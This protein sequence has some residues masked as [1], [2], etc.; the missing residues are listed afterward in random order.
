MSV[1]S[2]ARERFT[3]LIGRPETA[4]ELLE[5]ALWIAA[6]E[7]NDVDPEAVLAE[8]GTLADRARELCGAS[9]SRADR[10]AGLERIF[11]GELG[12]RGNA[13]DYYDPCNSDVAWV[14]RHRR[15]IPITLSVIFMEI[16]RRLGLEVEGV[17]FPG[18]FLVRVR[19]DRDALI[20]VFEARTLSEAD[21][22]A[23][24][25]SMYG[26]EA[27]LETAMLRACTPHEIL[28]RMLRNLKH[29]HLRRADYARALAC[30]DRLLLL[31][32]DAT[33]ELH[34]RGALYL[35]LECP[36]AAL[37]DLE[38]YLTLAPDGEAAD[39]VRRALEPL[40]EQAARLH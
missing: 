37:A 35:R 6:E 33:A 15:G 32:P 28:A 34:D 3:E 4:A 1:E 25:R 8:L 36:Q 9:A 23:K 5:A 10:L 17:G 13:E 2:S 18:H 22:A 40:R 26:D 30:C 31:E 16:G 7:C 29:A 39:A 24:L 20:D 14:L 19:G 11:F 12:F 38:R 21:C 27:T